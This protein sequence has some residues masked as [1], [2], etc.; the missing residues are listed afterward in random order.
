MKKSKSKGKEGCK[1]AE[2]NWEA[3]S[4]THLDVYKRQV[5]LSAENKWTHTFAD[6]DEK[7]NGNTITYTVREVSVPKGYEARNLSLIHI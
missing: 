6:L 7:A 3:V 2:K 4:Y 5:E 1:K